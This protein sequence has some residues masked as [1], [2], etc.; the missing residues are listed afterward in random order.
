MYWPFISSIFGILMQVVR[1]FRHT[2]HFRV[3]AL[4]SHNIGRKYVDCLRAVNAKN[5]PQNQPMDI[6]IYNMTTDTLD[7]LEKLFRTDYYLAITGQPMSRFPKACELQNMNGAG[8][9][10]NYANVSCKIFCMQSR[11]LW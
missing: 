7:K 10:E 5:N 6:A 4:R 1:F 9:G 11:T 8:L 3:Q 2:D